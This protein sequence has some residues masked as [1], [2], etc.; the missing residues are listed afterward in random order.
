MCLGKKLSIATEKSEIRRGKAERIL[1]W[2]RDA[3]AAWVTISS[4]AGP[5]FRVGQCAA[6]KLTQMSHT[7]CPG[8]ISRE[9]T[10]WIPARCTLNSVPCYKL[11]TPHHNYYIPLNPSKREANEGIKK[12]IRTFLQ[13][14]IF[15]ELRR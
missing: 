5:R 9:A 14:H 15:R 4:P 8:C 3:E 10:A 7:N 12:K 2:G 6:K 1:G 13:I 11:V